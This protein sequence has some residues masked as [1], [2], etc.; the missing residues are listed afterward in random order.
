M[1]HKVELSVIIP[2]YNGAHKITNILECLNKQTFKNF[3]VVIVIDGSTDDSMELLK[4]YR[5]FYPMS[6]IHQSNHGRSASRNTGVE[7]AHAT[8]LVFLDDDMLPENDFLKKHY[9]FHQQHP[10][11]I[12]VGCAFRNPGAAKTPFDRYLLEVE[13]EWKKGL[14]ETFKVSITNF[15]FTGANFSIDK[16]DFNTIGKFKGILP[17]TE[18]FDFGVRA[19]INNFDIYYD[20]NVVAWHN[21]FCSLDKF[22]NRL[23][24]Y[25][26]S[27]KRLFEINPEYKQLFPK[28]NVPGVKKPVKLF[29]LSIV[30]K[31]KLKEQWVNSFFFSCLPFKV[32]FWF[33]RLIISAHFNHS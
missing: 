28:H 29:M 6:I 22:I 24:E 27:N 12:L 31:L 8:L 19:L 20:I 7:S 15:A 10:N 16:S 11:S 18:D 2:S 14:G 9:E 5:P 33:Y 25:K 26:V 21:D 30:R 4:A 3:E 1:Q 23:K 17:D 13:K 32:Q